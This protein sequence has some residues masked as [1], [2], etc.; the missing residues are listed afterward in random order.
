MALARLQCRHR[1]I[2][3]TLC[4]DIQ[5]NL[6]THEQVCV[7]PDPADEELCKLKLCQG[8]FETH[9]DINTECLNRKVRVLQEGTVMIC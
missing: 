6:I 7:P 1:S 8:A 9:R 2:V 3:D 5:W 4:S